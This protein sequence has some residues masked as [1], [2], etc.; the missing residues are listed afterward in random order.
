MT[1]PQSGLVARYRGHDPG[2]PGSRY[3]RK[4]MGL[5]ERD[6]VMRKALKTT[7]TNN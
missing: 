2:R 7:R 5:A 4:R 6:K 1:T 3:M